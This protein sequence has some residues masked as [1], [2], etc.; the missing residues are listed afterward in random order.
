[1]K[2]FLLAA[3]LATVSANAHARDV[4]YSIKPNLP[5]V[6]TINGAGAQRVSV[7]VH[8]GAPQEL[9][10][11]DDEAVDQIQTPDINHDGYRDLVIGQSG[12]STQ[13]YARLFLYRPQ[14]GTFQEI[15][16][17]APD[18]SPCHQFVNP[19]FDKQ[20]AAFTVNCRY[21]AAS[22]GAEEYVLRA[23]GTARPVQWTSQ[24]LFD[25]E[26][27]AFELTTRFNDAGAVTHIQI[28]GEGSPLD[29]D[30]RVPVSRL[31]L[32]DAPDVKAPAPQSA[33]QGDRLDVVALQRQW[34]QVRYPAEQA[35]APLKWVRYADLK[36]DK[37]DYVPQQRAPM[38]GLQLSVRGHLGTQQY[39]AGGRFTL[40]VTN[41]GPGPASLTSPSIWLLFI[42]EPGRRLLQPLYQR[43]PVT[44]GSPSAQRAPVTHPY[45]PQD[46][47]RAAPPP[48]AASP[49]H[50]A[51]W[52]DDPVVWRAGED[53]KRQYQVSEGNGQ[54]VPFF[55]DLAPGR[56]R[57]AVVLTDPSLNA[58][59]YSNQIEVDYPFPKRPAP[60]TRS[61]SD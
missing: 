51:D 35:D 6:V 60:A 9:A 49:R 54:Y 38:S 61:R 29:G 19:A 11:L 53:G 43:S 46:E 17:P 36:I 14:D 40:H 4:P 45:P 10:E 33:K 18:A 26:N 47:D 58:P 28:D 44:L 56:Y 42:D 22:H 2:T 24:A 25:L 39:E 30:S 3:A 32:Y 50:V 1:M 12:G 20:R 5:A 41:L 8:G 23:D 52:A 59:V 48:A 55:P 15:R 34:L 13:V 31:D 27:T 16:H 57:L 21:G 37:Y 7:R